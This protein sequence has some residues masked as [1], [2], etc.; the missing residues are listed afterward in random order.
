MLSASEH[1]MEKSHICCNCHRSFY[2]NRAMKQYQQ[3]CQSK[4]KK[5]APMDRES[6]ET[7]ED[8]QF[9]TKTSIS[10]DEPSTQCVKY[11]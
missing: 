1:T 2:S 7:I 8:S 5:N 9:S 4:K 11:I 10:A 3:S 6:T